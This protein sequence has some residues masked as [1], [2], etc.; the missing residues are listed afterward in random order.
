MLQ[1]GGLLILLSIAGCANAPA[2]KATHFPTEQVSTRTPTEPVIAAAI[3]ELAESPS[4]AVR[5]PRKPCKGTLAE[6]CERTG[7]NCPTYEQAV[8]R[9]SALC[10]SQGYW[11]VTTS[12]CAGSYRSVRWN[13]SRL[14]GGEEF[15][16]AEGQLIAASLHTDYDAYCNGT[17][18]HQFFGEI[19]VCSGEVSS[20]NLCQ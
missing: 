17:S 14:G 19:P 13:E 9:R 10:S 15:F 12:E 18:F 11:S 1:L 4:A 16:D 8:E 2:T 20:K 3:N 5:E 7:G 6:Y